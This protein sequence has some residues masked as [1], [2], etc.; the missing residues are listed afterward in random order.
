MLEDY[1]V[2]RVDSRKKCLENNIKI[3]LRKMYRNGSGYNSEPVL[4]VICLFNDDFT[5]AEVMQ[6]RRVG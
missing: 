1:G 4:E 3:H 2:T 5:P 6:R